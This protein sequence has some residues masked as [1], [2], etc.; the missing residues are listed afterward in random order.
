MNRSKPHLALIVPASNTV[1]EPDFHRDAGDDVTVST[2]RIFLE[3]VSREAEER[4][5]TEELPRCLQ[6]LEPT[7][8]DVVVFGCTSAGS[9]NGL[10]HDAAIARSIEEQG[11]ADVVTVIGAMVSQLTAA[12]AERVA[13]FTPYTDEL[14]TSVAACISEAGFEVVRAGEPRLATLGRVD[15]GVAPQQRVHGR[16]GAAL[17]GAAVDLAHR[18]PSPARC[19]PAASSSG[20]PY[21]PERSW[22]PSE[23]L[24]WALASTT[25]M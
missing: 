15:L 8:P 13:V 23:R 3:D 12:S 22:N 18:P 11:G 7:H 16:G 25:A 10:G 1:M 5:L 4:M 6:E 19:V 20:A 2:W 14:T 17:R 9:L 24:A 21:A